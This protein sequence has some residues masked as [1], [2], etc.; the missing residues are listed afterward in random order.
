MEATAADVYPIEQTSQD[1]NGK[2]VY[3]RLPLPLTWD[4]VKKLPRV[5]KYEGVFYERLGWNSD[6]GG[7]SYREA[8]KVAFK[9]R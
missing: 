2:W 5:V 9:V 6:T 7:I 3:M 4:Q 1:E 8:R